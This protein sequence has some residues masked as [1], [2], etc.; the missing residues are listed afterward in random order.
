MKGRDWDKV[1]LPEGKQTQDTATVVALDAPYNVFQ[2]LF[3]S[4]QRGRGGE[5]GGRVV[6]Y[7]MIFL[8]YWLLPRK[9]QGRVLKLSKCE[10]ASIL[11]VNNGSASCASVITDQGEMILLCFFFFFFNS[12]AADWL[13]IFSLSVSKQQQRQQQ[14]KTLL[15][16]FQGNC[17]F[18]NV[19]R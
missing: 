18:A 2:D 9:L 6:C 5:G 16:W 19:L 14:Q 13:L 10:W 8:S 1:W 11:D 4:S 17:K 12:A 7:P 15:H 3:N